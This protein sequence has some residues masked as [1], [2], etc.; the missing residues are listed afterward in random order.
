[1]IRNVSSPIS[2]KRNTFVARV[3]RELEVDLRAFHRVAAP[4]RWLEVVPILGGG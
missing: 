2:V 3:S 4:V 1:M